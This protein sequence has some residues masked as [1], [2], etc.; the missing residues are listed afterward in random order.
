ME[1]EED[2]EGINDDGENKI[3]NKFKK[4]NIKHDVISKVILEAYI[5]R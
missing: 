4:V 2:R 5:R 3:K 1:V